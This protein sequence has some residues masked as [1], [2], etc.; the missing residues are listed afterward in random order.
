MGRQNWEFLFRSSEEAARELLG[1]VLC[2]EMQDKSVLRLRITE[3]EA[4]PGKDSAC[5]GKIGRP[6]EATAPLFGKGGTCCIYAGMLLIA[7]GPEKEPGNVLI[8]CA[9]DSE[10]N[11]YCDGPM[12]V[13]DVLKKKKEELH[14]RDLLAPGSVYLEDDGVLRNYCRTKRLHLGKTVLEKDREK[15]LRFVAL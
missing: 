11:I 15:Q 6:T 5:Y 7:C 2:C 9:G 4:Y 8:R 13:F 14:G 12:K 3:T 10:K 1:K